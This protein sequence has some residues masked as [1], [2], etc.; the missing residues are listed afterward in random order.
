MRWFLVV[1]SAA[2]AFAGAAR[3]T[4]LQ[5]VV[6]TPAEDVSIPFWCD[7][8]YDWDERCYRLN[9]ERLAVGGDI[10]KVWRSALRFSV[11]SVPAGARVDSAELSFWYDGTC[12]APRKTSIPCDGRGFDF[13]L[14]LVFTP[15]WSAE[16]EVDIG[17]QV[18][19]VSLPAASRPQWIDVE[20]TD[21]V[22]EWV[23]GAADNNGVL[24]RLADGQ[25]ALGASGPLFPSSRYPL[26]ELRPK[27]TVKFVL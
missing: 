17:P 2:L 4:E 16:R 12:V 24:L 15:R 18:A 26:K 10:D 27:L 11:A 14:H 22:G 6:V 21:L 23:S 8:G 1:V 7:W 9:E 25:E 13:A 19:F 3:A 20:V 5:T